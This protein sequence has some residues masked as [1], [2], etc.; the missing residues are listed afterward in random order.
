MKNK[1]LKIT[2]CLV[3][4]LATFGIAYGSLRDS[5]QENGKRKI[6]RDGSRELRRTV[7]DRIRKVPH[8]P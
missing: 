2:L 6:Q 1:T 3:A 4:V 5:F 8:L 7:L